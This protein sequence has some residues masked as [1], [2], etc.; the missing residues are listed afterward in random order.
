MP[1]HAM[2]CYAMP[3]RTIRDAAADVSDVRPCAW[4]HVFACSYTSGGLRDCLEYLTTGLTHLTAI[5]P[6]TRL[7]MA[8][9][10]RACA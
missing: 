3:C 10:W 5:V 2:L 7:A 9:V 8:H 1:R 4:H 6:G